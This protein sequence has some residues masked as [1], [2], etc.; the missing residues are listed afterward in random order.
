MFR[1]SVSKTGT[2]Q[3]ASR[4]GNE[5]AQSSSYLHRYQGSI[6][7]AVDARRGTFFSFNL[8]QN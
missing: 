2:A 4:P 1:Q 5:K 8:E 3:R 7:T 6:S